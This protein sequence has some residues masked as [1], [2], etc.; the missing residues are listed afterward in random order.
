MNGMVTGCQSK[1][2]Q[3]LRLCAAAHRVVLTAPY[4]PVLPKSALTTA[5]ATAKVQFKTADANAIV[6]GKSADA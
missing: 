4:F 6:D 2:L 1:H 5:E 3:T